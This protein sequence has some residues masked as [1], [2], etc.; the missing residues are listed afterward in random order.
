MSRWIE[1]L[2][3][4]R[5]AGEDCFL[6]TV[7]DVR[8]SAPREVGAKMLVTKDE[9]AGTIGG[10]QLEHQC[11]K[12]GAEH[13]AVGTGEPFVRRFT[14]G[15]NCGQCC[16]GVVEVLF[17]P[18]PAAG[19]AW[20]SDLE[21]RYDRRVPV[22]MVTLERPDKR[23]ARYLVTASECRA[24]G[25][26]VEALPAEIVARAREMLA[27]AADADADGDLAADIAQDEPPY[28]TSPDGTT[29]EGFD[30]SVP[31]TGQRAGVA[32]KPATPGPAPVPVGGEKHETPAQAPS[33]APAPTAVRL[34]PKHEK[35]FAALLD[36][37]V[38]TDFNIALF[39][40]G[41]TGT[42][43]VRTLT[44]MDCSLRW[45]DSRRGVFPE[46]LPGDV[47]CIETAHPESEVAA[48]PAGAYYLVMT[49]SHALDYEIVSRVLARG[50]FAYCG[51]I[52]SI[53]KRRRFERR[54]R[55]E[56][57]RESMLERLV[58][59]IGIAGIDSKQPEAIAIAVA[60][61]LLQIRS[62]RASDGRN[63]KQRAR[64]LAILR[65]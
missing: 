36:P 58:C 26:P 43:V 50:D 64:N 35:G 65:R 56:G 33:D 49:Y 22:V 42:A 21:E 52:G 51:L 53:S 20:L 14:L 16:G 1:D 3:D 15:A 45:I 46:R 13:L 19:S 54:L 55:K 61:E 4:V 23:L 18:V 57:I 34:R 9:I 32:D 47:T 24:Y 39:G 25:T 8:G 17:E 30:G 5:Q 44:G 31:E 41:H 37:L 12:L 2:R 28:S 11:T 48:M 7:M 27:G 10:G 6:V 38:P 62:A 29:C 40:A 60:A 59:P 63:D